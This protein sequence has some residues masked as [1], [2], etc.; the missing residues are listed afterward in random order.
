MG[1]R[2]LRNKRGVSGVIVTVLLIALAVVI[3]AIVWAVIMNLVEENVDSTK[4]CFGNF[5][6][7]TLNKRY[8]CY[9]STD[10]TVD[11]SVNVGDIE[12]D[13]VIVLVSGAGTTKSVKLA[14]EA[15]NMDYLKPYGGVWNGSVTSPGENSG[16]TYVLNLTKAGIGGLPDLIKIS[17]VIEGTQCESSDSITNLEPCETIA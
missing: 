2:T 1:G 11:F 8:T 5:N 17:P 6:K 4:A 15:S 16:K 7:V 12:I 9:D 10:Q 14:S 3:I 13:E